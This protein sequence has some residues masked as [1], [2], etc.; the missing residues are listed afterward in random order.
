DID[1]ALECGAELV[2]DVDE[3]RD[4]EGGELG[5]RR[6]RH[7]APSEPAHDDGIVTAHYLAVL[8]EPDVGLEPARP[9]LERGPKRRKRVLR[10]DESRTTMGEGDDGHD[11]ASCHAARR[12]SAVTRAS[13][14]NLKHTR[15]PAE[16]LSAATGGTVIRS[17]PG[18]G[19]A[20]TTIRAN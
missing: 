17:G 1:A 10:P 2:V 13:P 14:G 19:D 5:G 9:L 6:R 16:G 7:L 11:H 15:G 4:A 18:M 8:R 3:T 20:V 12:S